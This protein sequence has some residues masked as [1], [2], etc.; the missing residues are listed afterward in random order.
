MN[1]SEAVEA[2]PV[3][4]EWVRHMN[5]LNWARTRLAMAAD[6]LHDDLNRY[7]EQMIEALRGEFPSIVELRRTTRSKRRKGGAEP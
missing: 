2:G 6:Y 5:A 1:L 4:E 7:N 3:K